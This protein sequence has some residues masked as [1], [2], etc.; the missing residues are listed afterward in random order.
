MKYVVE[1]GYHNYY[2]FEN[3]QTALDF[4]ALA[5]NHKEN[6]NKKYDYVCVHIKDDDWNKTEGEDE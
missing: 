3:G 1:L 2:E 4:A 6:R 5:F